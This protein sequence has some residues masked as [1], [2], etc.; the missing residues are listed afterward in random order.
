MIDEKNFYLFGRNHQTC[1]FVVDHGSCSRWDIEMVR[2]VL[3]KNNP[4]VV[5][6]DGMGIMQS[7]FISK[8]MITEFMLPWS[9]TNTWREVFLLIWEAVSSQNFF[10]DQSFCHQSHFTAHGTFIG[11]FRLEKNK[12]TQLPVDSVFRFGES[13]RRFYYFLWKCRC[14]WNFPQVCDERKASNETQT[15]HGWTRKDRFEH[16]KAHQDLD[17]DYSDFSYRNWSRRWLAWFARDRK[18]VGQ[19]DRVQH[20]P[21]QTHLH[22]GHPQGGDVHQ[23]ATE[24]PYH[25]QRGGGRDQPMGCGSEH[26]EVYQSCSEHRHPQSKQTAES[27]T[28]LYLVT[29]TSDWLQGFGLGQ[30]PTMEHKHQKVT[31]NQPSQQVF[32][33]SKNS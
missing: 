6:D 1:D 14:W 21:K 26:W 11:N 4:A 24:D 27:G 31:S 25:L 15:S 5:C 10:D 32:H 23:E 9:G 20:C 16:S 3:T 7:H 18:W 2:S 28:S 22:D 17:L 30:A 8:I 29:I 33:P 13:T 12:P 19:P